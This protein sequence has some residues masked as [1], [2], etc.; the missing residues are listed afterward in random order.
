MDESN[1]EL[2]KKING[3]GNDLLL[4]EAVNYTD[5][6]TAESFAN[7]SPLRSK[8]TFEREFD[9]AN[10]ATVLPS[11][12]DHSDASLR[13]MPDDRSNSEAPGEPSDRISIELRDGAINT[14]AVGLAE[15]ADRT[16]N[17]VVIKREHSWD[18]SQGSDYVYSDEEAESG[19]KN[20]SYQ[21]DNDLLDVRDEDQESQTDDAGMGKTQNG[22]HDKEQLIDQVQRETSDGTAELVSTE[23]GPSVGFE[24]DNENLQEVVD[25][26]SPIWFSSEEPPSRRP[27]SSRLDFSDRDS[28]TSSEP[29]GAL[30]RTRKRRFGLFASSTRPIVDPDLSE[31]SDD[32][33]PRRLHDL[34]LKRRREKAERGLATKRARYNLRPRQQQESYSKDSLSSRGNVSADNFASEIDSETQEVQ[35][36]RRITRSMASRKSVKRPIPR[37][38][39]ARK[40]AWPLVPSDNTYR[41]PSRQIVQVVVPKIIDRSTWGVPPSS[42]SSRQIERR[43]SPGMNKDPVT[44]LK[45]EKKT[46]PALAGKGMK[47][48]TPSNDDKEKKQEL[49]FV[50]IE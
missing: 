13:R 40:S 2:L 22:T 15:D 50:L 32:A 38:K 5:M 25:L 30:N 14:E 24:D 43:Q 10:P 9:A 28:S 35:A 17:A 20:D 49:P 4:S 23:E 27:R 46:E 48:M 41:R 34:V 29:N 47:R 1:D 18:P 31:L 44:L 19:L 11:I 26:T 33:R 16:S 8:Q 21:Q 39:A 42:T 45:S 3:R 6:D 37:F 12:E 36:P 7:Q